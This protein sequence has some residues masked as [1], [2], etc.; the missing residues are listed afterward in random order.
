MTFTVNEWCLGLLFFLANTIQ[1]ITGFGSGMLA[2]P[3]GMT[4]VGRQM[5]S[6]QLNFFGVPICGYI[7][8]KERADIVWPV[9]VKISLGVAAGILCG[10]IVESRV[11]SGWLYRAYGA[12]I[13]FIALFMAFRKKQRALPAAVSLV[14]MVCAGILQYI[15]V[16]GGPLMV[17]AAMSMLPEKRSFHATINAIWVP[18]SLFVGFGHWRAG[19]YNAD[20]FRLWV[21]VLPAL[22]LGTAAGYYLYRRVNTKWFL[23]I[24]YIALVAMGSFILF[25]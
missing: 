2:M 22:V 9:V 21:I 7:A 15:F 20:F 23:R 6:S 1:T 4:L 17:L 5:V 11:P 24:S 16:S 19:Y 18:I 13:I 3:V 14:L 25:F 12:F 10:V 8:W